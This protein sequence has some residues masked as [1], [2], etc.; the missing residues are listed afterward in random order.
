M[1]H[2]CRR[3]VDHD[4]PG[5]GVTLAARRIFLAC[6][7]AQSGAVTQ[8]DARLEQSTLVWGNRRASGVEAHD[9]PRRGIVEVG[10][11]VAAIGSAEDPPVVKPVLLTLPEFDLED[12]HTESS[13]M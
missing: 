2:A 9:F 11:I 10:D 1:T 3:D 7:V 6:A 5:L 8:V 12:A 13:P 4:R